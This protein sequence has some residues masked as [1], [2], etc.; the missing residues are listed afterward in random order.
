MNGHPVHISIINIPNDLVGQQLSIVLTREVGLS[1]PRTVKLQSLPDPL[2]KHVKGGV[3]LHDLG[4]GLLSKRLCT[5]E[6]VIKRRVEI[7]SQVDCNENSSRRGTCC[8]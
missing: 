8:P 1:R 7:I 5:R 6:P 2:P 3:S 4:H